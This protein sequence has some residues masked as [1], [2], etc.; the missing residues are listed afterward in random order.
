MI[1]GERDGRQDAVGLA[2]EDGAAIADPR[3]GETAAA[4][5]AHDDRRAAELHVDARFC[6]LGVDGDER[7]AQR[8]GW[9]LAE[10][11]ATLG[12]LDE[13]PRDALAGE[14]RDVVAVGPVAVEDGEEGAG[15]GGEIARVRRAGVLVGPLRRGF[16]A[17]AGHGGD[18]EAHLGRAVVVEVVRQEGFRGD[19]LH[20]RGS[21]LGRA[22]PRLVLVGSL[23][24]CEGRKGDDGVSKEGCRS[25]TRPSARG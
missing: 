18:H 22:L 20:L 7:A 12:I 15:G 11:R 1:S 19:N 4:N 3:G 14:A 13:P 9:I 17:G 8:G 24:P 21:L 16:R 25:T 10:E 2:S 23:A 6:E 5:V